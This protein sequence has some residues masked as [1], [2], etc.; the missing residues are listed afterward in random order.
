MRNQYGID[1]AALDR[2]ITGNWGED[3]FADEEGDCPNEEALLRCPDCRGE[4]VAMTERQRDG[5][6]ALEHRA[7]QLNAMGLEGMAAIMQTHA[8]CLIERLTGTA[9]PTCK[10]E[11]E[12]KGQCDG[13]IYG[14]ECE[15]C[16]YEADREDPFHD[17]DAR[18]E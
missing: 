6:G 7:K 12:V 17:P 8:A 2:H 15:T 13:T 3:Q 16:G 10:G 4:A 5:I 14:G 18:D 11:G 9:C 1:P